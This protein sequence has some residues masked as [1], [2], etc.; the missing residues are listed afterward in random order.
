MSNTDMRTAVAAAF[1]DEYG[2]S[3]AAAAMVV[4]L[5]FTVTS[6]SGGPEAQQRAFQQALHQ[7]AAQ[8]ESWATELIGRMIQKH[9][10]AFRVT[11][12]R[13]LAQGED[14]SAALVS[15]HEM[16]FAAVVDDVLT[17]LAA[18]PRP[19]PSAFA[20]ISCT[21]ARITV[22]VDPNATTASAR[23]HTSD[24]SGPAAA[25]A[26]RANAHL[27]GERLIVTVPAPK[28]L[29]HGDYTFH[30]GISGFHTVAETSTIEID[31]T[32]PPASGVKLRGRNADLTVH[33]PLSTLDTET[34][35]GAVRA[36]AL[37]KAK[38]RTRS[39][40]ITIDAVHDEIDGE[41]HSGTMTIGTYHG[42]AA[43]LVS[44]SGDIRFTAASGARGTVS[45]TSRSGSVR[46]RHV[47]ARNGLDVTATSHSG[48]VTIT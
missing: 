36:G 23:V 31:V 6:S 44:R 26:R 33:G 12:R 21:N 15:E 2:V 8:G 45:A 34:R 17:L 18:E 10:S 39:G 40:D 32:V 20:D 14:P 42:A 29:V 35:E 19:V 5:Y 47:A 3:E 25:A 4:N 28:P 11:Y 13:A 48:T 30:G 27:L 24:T 38:L 43:R 9:L 16:L 41:T 46:L 22:T 37:G 1:I 7:T